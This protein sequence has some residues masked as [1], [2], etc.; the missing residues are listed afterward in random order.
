M[1]LRGCR[2]GDTL[3]PPVIVVS[4]VVDVWIVLGAWWVFLALRLWCIV[5]S[6][7]VRGVGDR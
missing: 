4:I 5:W 1:L 2:A 3:P 7:R 6:K